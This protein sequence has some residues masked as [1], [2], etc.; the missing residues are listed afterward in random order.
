M[1]KKSLLLLLSLCLLPWSLGYSLRT[2]TEDT[3][4]RFQQQLMGVVRDPSAAL[5]QSD[6]KGQV[7][8]WLDSL[9]TGT[10]KQYN[11]WLTNLEN[12]GNKSVKDVLVNLSTS[13]QRALTRV[14]MIQQN[15]NYDLAEKREKINHVFQTMKQHVR[16]EINK[17]LQS[18]TTIS[19]MKSY[20]NGRLNG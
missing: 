20:K 3:I 14:M 10:R 7:N 17:S 18:T 19:P 9:D 12:F 2:T 15:E 4:L 16:D 8:T 11:M 5:K 6:V 1:A 13:S